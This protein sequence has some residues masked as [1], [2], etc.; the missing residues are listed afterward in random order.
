MMMAYESWFL[1]CDPE[2][3]IVLK[4]RGGCGVQSVHAAAIVVTDVMYRV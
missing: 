2:A 3:E 4:P 1:V